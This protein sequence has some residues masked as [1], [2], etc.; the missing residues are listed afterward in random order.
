MN[1]LNKRKCTTCKV[2]KLATNDFFHRSKNCYLGLEYRCKECSKLRKDKRK[3]SD[4]WDNMT[5]CQKNASRLAKNKYNK[6]FKGRCYA[7]LK[8][9]QKIDKIKGFK[10]DLDILYIENIK[11]QPCFYCTYPSTGADRIDNSLG[12]LKSNC[13]PCCKECNIAR[14]DLFTIDEMIILGKAIKKI[15]DKR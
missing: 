7:T 14:N 4:R 11:K 6:S 12:H 2:I 9:Y 10:N 15:K 3:W 1:E 8:A 13:V 5:E